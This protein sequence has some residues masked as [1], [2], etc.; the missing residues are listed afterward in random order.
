VGVDMQLSIISPSKK[1]IFEVLW[2]ECNTPTGSYVIQPGHAPMI[3]ALSPKKPFSFSL[4][5]GQEEII[6]I[7]QGIA[8]IT[9]ESVTLLINQK[10]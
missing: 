9:R 5:N 6:M 4:K 2:V 10:D 8:H 7:Q 1:E 3:L